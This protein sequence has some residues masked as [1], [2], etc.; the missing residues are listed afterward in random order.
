MKESNEII[1]DIMLVSD[2]IK[3][4][5][6]RIIELARTGPIRKYAFDGIYWAEDIAGNKYWEM[7]GRATQDERDDYLR[8]SDIKVAVQAM[9]R[10]VAERNKI[11]KCTYRYRMDTE[12]HLYDN[13][14]DPE[15][16]DI[17]EVY[18][19]KPKDWPDMNEP[20][21]MTPIQR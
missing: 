19:T 17:T 5:D 10:F 3:E 11:K 6:F 15:T 7:F 9:A 18:L 4:I 12:G 21:H 14:E 16:V 20:I 1:D 2:I 13:K 8:Y